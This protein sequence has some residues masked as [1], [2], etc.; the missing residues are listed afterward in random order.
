MIGATTTIGNAAIAAVVFVTAYL[1]GSFPNAYLIVKRVSGEDITAHGSGNVGAMNVRRT[2]GSWRWFGIAMAADFLKG[3]A[4][5]AVTK[6]VVM[7]SVA[8]LVQP[9]G[10]TLSSVSSQWSLNPFYYVPMA[11]VAGAVFGHNYSL[12]L[13]IVKRHFMRTGKGLA[14]GA[15]AL[16]AYDWRY[17]LAV[18]VVGL[19]VIAIS[20]YMMAGQVVAS[21]TVP[22][23]AILLRSPDWIFATVM[24]LVVYAAH[25]KRFL[26]LLA[27]KEPKFYVNDRQG[28]TG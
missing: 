8:L 28:P 19:T 24:G 21:F 20:R 11:A 7:G 4:P 16:L 15:G 14:T 1:V 27:G 12:W 3:L 9:W 25:H 18:V 17:F 26:G 10:V 13:A 6:F 5:V 2:T 22:L 23:A